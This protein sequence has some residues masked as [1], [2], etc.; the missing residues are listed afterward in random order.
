MW[1]QPVMEKNDMI[2]KFNNY[3]KGL[4]DYKDKNSPA[5]RFRMQRMQVFERQFLV[6]FGTGG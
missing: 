6:W 5:Y 2:Q 3:L 4:V 1:S